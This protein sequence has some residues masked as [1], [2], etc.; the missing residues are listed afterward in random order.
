M[1][2]LL[3]FV[4]LLLALPVA[5]LSQNTSVTATLTDSDSV[6][7]TLGSCTTTLIYTKQ[8]PPVAPYLNS[9]GTFPLSP[10]CSVNG[11]G[12]LNVTLTDVKFIAPI[13]N[14]TWQ[15]TVCPNVGP[16]AACGTTNIPVTGA[17]QNVSSLLNLPPPRVGGGVGA[18]AYA[19]AEVT[20][21]YNNLYWNV[22]SQAC[23]QYT[24]AWFNCASA[25]GTGTVTLFSASNWPSWLTPSVATAS[26]TPVLS[27][28]ASAIPNNALAN[29]SITL[30]STSVSLGGTQTSLSGLTVN[31]VTLSAAGS[32]NSFLN[33]AGGYTTPAASGVPSVNTYAGPLV[34]SFSAG[35]GSCSNSGGTTT[36]TITGSS[37]GSGTVTNFIA[38]S[39]SWPTWLVPSVA[40][41]TTTP[42]LS[43]T[44]SAIPNSALA[45]PSLTLGSTNVALGATQTSLAGLT[46]TTTSVNGVTLTAAGSATSFLNAAGGYT[47]PTGS[48]TQTICSGTLSLG[49]SAIASGAAATTVTASCSGLVSTDN[50]MLDF[51]ASPLGVVGYE[52]STAGMLTIIKWPTANT[53]NVSVVNNTASSV[54]PGAITLNYRVVR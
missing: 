53:I 54:T 30:G 8:S 47:T 33:Q 21:A 43:V 9:G 11:L 45:N 19:D 5:A 13:F 25:S 22:V 23:R 42:T 2:K 12:Q 39:G 3:Q 16:N 31:G 20:V 7:W 17:S 32:A 49:T 37:S 46:L 40:T 28:T 36:C 44:P 27:V 48:G 41:G 26:S 29:S 52:P 1:R 18:T 34:L 6:T 14:A 10:Q 51:N 15:F 38:N 24:T 35:A 50:I 4:L